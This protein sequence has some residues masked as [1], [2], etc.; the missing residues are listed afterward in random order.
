M[1]VL[2]MDIEQVLQLATSM[3]NN[4]EQISQATSQLTGQIDSTQWMGQ[5]QSTFRSDWDSTYRPQ[6]NNVVQALQ[7]R[8]SHLKQEAAQQQQASGN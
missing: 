1:A 3:Q 4:A 8:C 6:L 7:D 2:G 5:D